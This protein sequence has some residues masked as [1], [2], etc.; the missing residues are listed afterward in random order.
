[1]LRISHL[2]SSG[3]DVTLRLEGRVVGP[4]VAELRR[5]C[6]DAGQRGAR[7][8]LDLRDVLFLDREAIALLQA[9]T[10]RDVAL[11]HC[12]PFVAQQLRDARATG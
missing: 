11:R 2:E 1:M 9:L 5:A 8:T 7:V 10:D 3:Q 4:W 6:E 12:S